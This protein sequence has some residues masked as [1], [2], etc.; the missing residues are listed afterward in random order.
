MKCMICNHEW[1]ATPI[2]KV[3]NFIN[4]GYRGC[5][6]CYSNNRSIEERR[7]FIQKIIDKGF[8]IL[9]T[10]DG[11]QAWG[12]KI[13]VRNNKC[14]HEFQTDPRNL[15]N[16]NLNCPI[17]NKEEKI[18]RLNANSKARSVEWQ[19][20]AEMWDQYRHKVYMATRAV[21]RKHQTII[22]PLNLPRGLAGQEGAYHLDHI[23]PVRYCFLNY[24]PVEI[25]AHVDNLQMVSWLENLETKDNLKEGIKIP[26]IFTPFI[27]S[28]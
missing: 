24:I 5:P 25:C 15:G 20:T 27:S 9:S 26:E 23:V 2:S 12:A 6:I 19:K 4:K 10:Y 14:L 17:C 13:L 1:S 21:Y 3:H 28:N 16:K 22:N 18:K 11:S 7:L 8:T